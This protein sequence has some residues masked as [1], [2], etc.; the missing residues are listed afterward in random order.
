MKFLELKIPPVL[1]FFVTATCMW[2][3]TLISNELGINTNIRFIIGAVSLLAGGFIAISGIVG[4][5]KAKTTV[6]PTKPD[7]A[8]SL[9]CSGIYRYTRN[10]MYTGLLFVLIAWSCFLDNLFSLLFVFAYL[11]YMTQFQIKPE[12][13]VLESIFGKNYNNYKERVRRWL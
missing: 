11:L 8:S 4:F 2:S 6:N 7:K 10:P 12:E 9:V 13:R 5:R 3:M 1:F